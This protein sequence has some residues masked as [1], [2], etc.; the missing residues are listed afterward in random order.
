MRVEGWVG[1]LSIR[2][3]LRSLR[4]LSCREVWISLGRNVPRIRCGR[5]SRSCGGMWIAL[6]RDAPRVGCHGH[7]LSMRLM[8]D[9]D[10]RLPPSMRVPSEWDFP[11]SGRV[12]PSLRWSSRNLRASRERLTNVSGWVG[13]TKNRPSGLLDRYGTSRSDLNSGLGS[14]SGRCV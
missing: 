4:I 14:S 8:V 9:S 7:G 6:K 12:P 2:S 10:L 13:A 11:S 3:L 1:H 5:R